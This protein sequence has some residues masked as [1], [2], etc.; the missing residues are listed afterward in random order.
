MTSVKRKKKKDYQRVH[1]LAV[2]NPKVWIA[3]VEVY[4]EVRSAFP[5]KPWSSGVKTSIKC[6]FPPV[7]LSGRRN[8]TSQGTLL[9]K[10]SKIFA[11]IIYW[12]EK[13][14]LRSVLLLEWCSFFVSV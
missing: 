4:H 12:A 6:V 5:M 3:G 14:I 9:I 13:F 7:G 11:V 8:C 10:Q 2:P 1:A